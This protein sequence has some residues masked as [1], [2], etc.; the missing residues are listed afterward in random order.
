MMT[1]VNCDDEEVQEDDE[2]NREELQPLTKEEQTALAEKLAAAGEDKWK[3][4]TRKL[5]FQDDEVRSSL[6]IWR[7][8]K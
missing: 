4:L 3:V 6:L 7:K 2:N 1:E 8:W 5:G